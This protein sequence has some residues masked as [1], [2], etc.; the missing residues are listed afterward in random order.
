M[1]VTYHWDNPERTVLRLIAAGEWSWRDFHRAAQISRVNMM[2]GSDRIDTIV[3]LR[4]TDRLPSGIAA[5]VR[6]FGRPENPRQTG[7]A[8]VIGIDA[9]VVAKLAGE[10]RT[11]QMSGDHVVVFVDTDEEALNLLE[12]WQ[13]GDEDRN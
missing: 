5:H 11:L 3:D 8:V 12:R 4:D 6:T 13:A 2:N 1:P 9:N 10:S 7:R